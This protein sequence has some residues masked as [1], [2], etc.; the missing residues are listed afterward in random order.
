MQG[1]DKMVYVNVCLRHVHVHSI[2]SR[3]MCALR[4]FPSISQYRTPITEHTDPTKPYYY[5][6]HGNLNFICSRALLSL[7]RSVDYFAFQMIM[8][9]D[10]LPKREAEDT[11]FKIASLLAPRSIQD[12]PV[13]FFFY[14]IF[15]LFSRYL[16]SFRSSCEGSIIVCDEE[17]E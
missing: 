10:A 9:N 3:A 8:E 11:L 14:S 1:K 15:P 12:V 5:T 2:V 4:T 16:V 7:S 17:Q 6:I 13:H